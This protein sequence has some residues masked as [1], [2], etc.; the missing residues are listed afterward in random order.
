M[1][2][3]ISE[4]KENVLK[5]QKQHALSPCSPSNRLFVNEPDVHTTGNKEQ[6]R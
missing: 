1:N 6:I 3:V 2:K 5:L 4:P